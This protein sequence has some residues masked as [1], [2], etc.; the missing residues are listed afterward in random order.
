MV[1]GEFDFVGICEAPDD[2]VMARFV[3]QVG[4]SVSYED[5]EGF[6]GDRLPRN[7]PRAAQTP[8]GSGRSMANS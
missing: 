7:C 6:P 4:A 1:M 3:L 5:A 8:L 2:A